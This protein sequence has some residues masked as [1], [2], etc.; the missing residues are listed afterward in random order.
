MNII[1]TL[2]LLL[3]TSDVAKEVFAGV[4]N[5]YQHDYE[6]ISAAEKSAIVDSFNNARA[7]TNPIAADMQAVTWG[8]EM[9]V[10]LNNFTANTPPAFFFEDT[11]GYSYV[12]P[13][14]NRTQS[15]N[16]QFILNME[17]FKALR[18]AGWKFLFHDTDAPSDMD[19]EKIIKFRIDQ[20][21]CFNYTKCDQNQFTDYVSC[22]QYPIILQSSALCSWFMYYY[23]PMLKSDLSEIACVSLVYPG[24]NTP[25]PGK[26]TRSFWCYGKYLQ[27]VSDRPFKAGA[28][29][30]ECPPDA[31]HCVDGFCSDTANTG[32]RS[33]RLTAH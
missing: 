33:L 32:R 24:P 13:I 11:L 19:I 9:Q 1:R 25:S 30:S 7:S 3:G 15:Y 14:L 29:C 17:Q 8:N 20:K 22:A 5:N 18:E 10:A 2:A 26:Q 16:G 28:A 4:P 27:P 12:V 31:S 21:K 6:T 23:P